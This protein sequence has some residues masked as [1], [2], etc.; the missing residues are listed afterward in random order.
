MKYV[1]KRSFEKDV[2]KVK[3][4]VLKSRIAKVIDEVERAGSIDNIRNKRMLIGSSDCFRI[5]IGD[6]RI[7]CVFDST[8][9]SVNFVR[10]GHRKNFYRGFS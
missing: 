6:C 7:G 5:R 8:E 9:D 4:K 3:S 1:I 10:F 2:S